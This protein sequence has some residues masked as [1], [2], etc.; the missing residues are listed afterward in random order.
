[1]DKRNKLEAFLETL[2]LEQGPE[3]IVENLSLF[4]G[5]FVLTKDGIVIGANDAFSEMVAYKRDALCGMQAVSLVPD[6]D[7]YRLTEIFANC[8]TEPYI[9]DLLRR[10]GSVLHTLVSPYFS[11]PNTKSIDSR[12]LWTSLIISMRR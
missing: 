4:F 3:G 10:D 2:F 9:I 8:R 6:R 12:N 11:K 7:K 1:M 5:A